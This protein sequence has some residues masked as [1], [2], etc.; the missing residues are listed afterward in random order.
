MV[1][2]A[3]AECTHTGRRRRM[4]SD[5]WVVVVDVTSA[6]TGATTA[7]TPFSLAGVM[8]QPLLYGLHTLVVPLEAALVASPTDS[9]GAVWAMAPPVAALAAADFDAETR[10]AAVAVSVADAV[11]RLSDAAGRESARTARAR[12]AA[13]LASAGSVDARQ[14]LL[15]ALVHR[16][17]VEAAVAAGAYGLLTCECA[18]TMAARVLA[19]V[20]SG[21]G[22]SLPLDTSRL[23]DRHYDHLFESGRGAHP[24]V[25]HTSEWP[26]VPP[27][28]WYPT[29][30]MILHPQSPPA[31]PGSLLILRPLLEVE[32][33]ETAMYCRLRGAPPADQPSFLTAAREGSS[34]DVASA[35][36]LASLQ[37]T[38]AHTVHNVVRTTQKLAWLSGGEG[39]AGL[40]LSEGGVRPL[41]AVCAS[42]LVGEGSSG[43][44]VSCARTLKCVERAAADADAPPPLPMYVA[45]ALARGQLRRQ[46]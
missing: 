38:Y 2:D 9:S 32:A 29:K 39:G 21:R 11:Q 18:D 17:L 19:G 1:L 30:L 4:F 10:S 7:R 27:S 31:H 44:C 36:L 5:A 26:P 15:R 37:A 12:L 34:I 14:D 43:V 3:V 45:A 22:H 28:T 23:D 24:C 20:C 16:V 40:G 8:A 35:A 6:F 25:S 41:C 13:L 46:Q 33:Q 42:L